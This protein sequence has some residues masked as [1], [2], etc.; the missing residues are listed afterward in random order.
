MSDVM[1]YMDM[2]VEAAGAERARTEDGRRV[3][4]FTVR[5]LDSPAGEMRPEE[6]VPSE[7]DEREALAAVQRLEER[8]LERAGLVA[9]GRRLGEAL[10]PGAVREMLAASLV[11]AAA[12]GHGLRLRL[13]LPAQLA[14]LP[15]EVIHV[16]RSG[17][18]E[19]EGFLALDP[20][21]ALVRH[22]PLAAVDPPAPAPGPVR[23]VVALASPEDLPPVDLARNRRAIE[24]ALGG[25]A[26][27]EAVYLKDAS[28]EDVR[29]AVAGAEV[30]H[31][32]G[33]GALVER[34]TPDGTISRVGTVA[35]DDQRVDAELLGANLR[36]AGVRLAVLGGCETGRRD[37]TSIWSGVAPALIRAEVPAVVAH[38][39]TVSEE[40]ARV[41]NAALYGAL[42]GGAPLEQA[43]AAGRLAIFNLEPQGAEWAVPVL[44]MRAA[45]GQ[46]FAGAAEPEVREQARKVVNAAFNLRVAELKDSQVVGVT[47]GAVRDAG[48]AGIIN[49]TSDVD[50]G[51]VS[52][53]SITG[54]SIGEV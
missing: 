32:T 22:D 1:R 24:G 23:V 37:G 34:Q 5:V 29:A 39:L 17:G 50:A 31:F 21:L 49:A 18:G 14:A 48:G 25:A 11:R 9:L 46:L 8:A 38:Q 10:L 36:G 7:L 26:G 47:I 3:L 41:F 20:R 40:G 2:E 53:G 13:R 27:I 28:L 52:G 44:S 43:V 35:L 19:S 12:D 4:R 33:H 54:V 42:V 6:V 30:F 15:W 51:T 16:E 45:D